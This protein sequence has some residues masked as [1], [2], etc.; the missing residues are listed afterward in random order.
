MR[1]NEKNTK[2]RSFSPLVIPAEHLRQR[3]TDC[4]IEL[5]EMLSYV[6]HRIFNLGSRVFFGLLL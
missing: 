4:R 2:I 6:K 5:R 1:T 3:S